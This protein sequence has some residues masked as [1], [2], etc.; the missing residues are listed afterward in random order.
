MQRVA[1]INVGP[2]DLRDL[3]DETWKAIVKANS[4][5]PTLFRNGDRIVWIQ[6]DD[7]GNRVMKEVNKDRLRHY[8]SQIILFYRLQAKKDKE[9]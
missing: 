1:K 5:T 9:E 2:Q 8:L 4:P 3:S 6:E 7:Q